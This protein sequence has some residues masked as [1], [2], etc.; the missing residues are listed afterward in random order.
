MIVALNKPVSTSYSWRVADVREQLKQLI[1]DVPDF[2]KEGIVFKDLTPVFLDPVATQA[3]TRV[4]ADRFHALQVDAIAAIES[5]GFLI[6][7]PVAAA[8][9]VP[10]A[11]VRK[12]GKLPR[13]TIRRSYA[14]EYGED[15]LEM[16]TDA[17]ASG[18]RVV[19]VDDLLA[20]GGTANATV[21]LIREAGAEV[22]E[23]AFM[24]ELSFLNGRGRLAADVHALVQY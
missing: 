24:V 2:P 1:K 10:L 11:L 9:G 16:H 14:L 8:L 21:E 4:F 7:A 18:Q 6:G 17:V 23:A 12:P 20:T 15:T 5:R 13:R 3:M 19:I 22:V